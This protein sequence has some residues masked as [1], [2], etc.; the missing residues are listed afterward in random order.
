VLSD[1]EGCPAAVQRIA[2][3]EVTIAG[4]RLLAMKV[5]AN[6]QVIQVAS[7]AT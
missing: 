5:Y 6:R 2:V 3:E 1:D 7:L 4:E